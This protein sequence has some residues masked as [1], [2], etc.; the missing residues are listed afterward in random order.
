MTPRAPTPPPSPPSSLTSG[1]PH[2]ASF[3]LAPSISSST[4]ERSAPD[5]CSRRSQGAAGMAHT[6]LN[7]H[8]QRLPPKD[9]QAAAVAVKASHGQW[10]KNDAAFSELPSLPATKGA[11]T[12]SLLTVS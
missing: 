3:F 7:T 5:S 12:C 4:Y 8:G 9:T 1:T 2:F 11:G 10:A 6:V